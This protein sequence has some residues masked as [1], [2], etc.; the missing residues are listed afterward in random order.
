MYMSL[1]NDNRRQIKRD[2]PV[3][4]ITETQ[5]LPNIQAHH[6][7][8]KKLYGVGPDIRR[9]WLP[10]IQHLPPN[11]WRL[12]EPIESTRPMAQKGGLGWAPVWWCAR[13]HPAHHHARR[14]DDIKHLVPGGGM[15]LRTNCASDSLPSYTCGQEVAN[16]CG[17][18]VQA[19][20]LPMP[21]NRGSLQ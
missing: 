1:V 2:W 4:E 10:D 16:V 20:T 18:S 13:A 9:G 6:K 11:Q 14:W 19:R 15:T 7:R 12:G 17:A 3:L 21:E 8:K 5:R